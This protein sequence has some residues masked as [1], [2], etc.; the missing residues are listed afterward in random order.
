MS[1]N[2]EIG[3]TDG[4]F[5]ITYTNGAFSLVFGYTAAKALG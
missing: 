1:R 5:L 3:D 4:R 2:A